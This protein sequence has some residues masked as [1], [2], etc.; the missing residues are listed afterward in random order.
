MRLLLGGLGAIIAWATPRFGRKRLGCGVQ[1]LFGSTCAAWPGRI[2]KRPR[3]AWLHSCTPTPSSRMQLMTWHGPTHTTHT[4]R[5][6]NQAMEP[7]ERATNVQVQYIVLL[8][9]APVGTRQFFEFRAIPSTYHSD[10][11]PFPSSSRSPSAAAPSTTRRRNAASCRS[12]PVTRR[13]ASSKS[14]TAPA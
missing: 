13:S 9:V 10:L 1:P 12:S 8:A 14:A 2:W 11:T 5:P 3:H 7:M 4:H 6:I